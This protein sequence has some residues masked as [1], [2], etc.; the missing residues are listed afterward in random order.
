MSW[1][2]NHRKITVVLRVVLNSGSESIS[3]CIRW[4]ELKRLG[5]SSCVALR[6]SL[7]SEANWEKRLQIARQHKKWKVMWSDESRVTLFQSDGYFRVRREEDAVMHPLS[8]LPPVQ[9]CRGS[10]ELGLVQLV[11]SMFSYIICPK[12][13][14]SWLP[15]YTEWPGYSIS[16]LLFL[17][18]Y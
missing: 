12:N 13:E 9:A 18:E 16:E 10:S 7:I 11:R 15:E 4:R 17:P 8:L 1:K 5:L 6:K 3:T 14:V 2:S